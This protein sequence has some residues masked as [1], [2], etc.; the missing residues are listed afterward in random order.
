MPQLLDDDHIE[1][2][3]AG[4]AHNGAA[5]DGAG[6]GQG[7]EGKLEM[8]KGSGL[9]EWRDEA[10]REFTE[11]I[12]VHAA[13]RDVFEDDSFDS[14]LVDAGASAPAPEPAPPASV[15]GLRVCLRPC[16]RSRSS[17]AQCR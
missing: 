11:P 9:W 2:P 7:A 6:S 10:E 14:P 15:C 12:N 17:W 4:L 13:Q 5:A 16:W 8:L 1:E 3:E